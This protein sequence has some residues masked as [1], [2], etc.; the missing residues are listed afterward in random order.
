MLTCKELSV[1]SGDYLEHALPFKKKA[2]VLLH[3]AICKHCRHYLSNLQT[4]IDVVRKHESQ[5]IDSDK[6][7]NI[8]ARIEA[9]L[10]KR[11]S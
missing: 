7:D 5:T 9:G 2:S 11:H 1:L 10:S 6:V 3:L 8:M 4:T